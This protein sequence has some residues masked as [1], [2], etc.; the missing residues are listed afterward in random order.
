MNM[1]AIGIDVS[2][3]KSMVSILRPGEE[4]VS[5]PFEMSHLSGDIQSLISRIQSLEGE[6]RIVMECTG[7]YYKP[8][9]RQLTAAGLFVSTVNPQLIHNYQDEDN[10]LR[11]VKSDKEDSLKIARYTLDRWTKLK[12]YDLM[13]KVRNQLKTMNRQFDFYMK[14]KTAMKNNLIGLLDQTYLGVNTYFDS[15][16]HEDGSQKWVDFATTYWHVDCVRKMSRNA[17]V[18]QYQKWCICKKYNF[19]ETK[20][21]EIN[22]A[23]KEMVPVLPKDDFTKRIIK[24]VAE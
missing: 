6:S 15:P 24:Q 16:S 19:S 4:V 1:N 13:D 18:E 7:R 21:E 20:A 9:A 17:F 10:S 5:R 11:K 14:H 3:R 8:I 12:Q 22:E 2:K 23:A